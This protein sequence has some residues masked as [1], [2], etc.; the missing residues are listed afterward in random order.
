M[1]G[2]MAASIAML[3]ISLSGLGATGYYLFTSRPATSTTALDASHATARS[4]TLSPVTNPVSLNLDPVTPRQVWKPDWFD[5]K[6]VTGVV[7]TISVPELEADLTTIDLTTFGGRVGAIAVGGG[8]RYLVMHFPD[9]GM[10][11]V[12]D[13]SEGRFLGGVETNKGDVKLTAGLSWVITSA[14]GS[15]FRA[16][17]LPKL[18]H[19]YD[20]TIE[21]FG[22]VGAMTMGNRTD[23]PLLVTNPFGDLVLLEIGAAGL[24]EVEGSRKKPGIVANSL[25][26]TPDGTAFLSYALTIE[27]PQTKNVKVLTESGRDWVVTTLDGFV[28]TPGPDGNFYGTW[29][30][31][32]D[33]NGQNL[34]FKAGI[35][36]SVGRM[37]FLPQVTRQSDLPLTQQ[38]Y[39]VRAISY[40]RTMIVNPQP[41]PPADVQPGAKPVPTEVQPAG[42]PVPQLQIKPMPGA[43]IKA[44][45]EPIQS[46]VKQAQPVPQPDTPAVPPAQPVPQ[47]IQPVPQPIQPMPQPIRITKPA[48]MV[49]IHAGGNLQVPAPNTPT[50]MALPEFDGLVDATGMARPEI[51]QHFYLIPEAKLLVILSGD[52]TKLLLRKLN[53]P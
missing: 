28:S 5:L 16:F 25:R 38:G 52:R 21:L 51:D 2:V 53:I 18:E 26:A 35:G 32:M 27:P 20:A 9:K 49:T 4:A 14:A 11:N 44:D 41:T 48:L 7:P 8:G 19:R 42:K 13:A 24:K 47:P 34:L 36:G 43:A 50:L 6:P 22:G 46:D 39:T 37:W 29:A 31:A 15:T 12:F 45:A 30:T 17:S 40:L 33:R 23:G 10:L 3:F 1:L